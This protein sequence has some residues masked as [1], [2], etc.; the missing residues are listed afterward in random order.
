MA[1]LDMVAKR[2]GE[3]ATTCRSASER[4]MR[5]ALRAA[6]RRVHM[7]CMSLSDFS[8]PVVP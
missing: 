3:A 1:A 4:I 7:A 8:T 5:G 6:V 2:R